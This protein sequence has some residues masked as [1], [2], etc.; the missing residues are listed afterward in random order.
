MNL[1]KI[2]SRFFRNKHVFVG[3]P[4]IIKNSNGDILLG[5]RDDNAPFYPSTWGLPGG[6]IEYGERIEDATKR[7]VE[8]E[9][10]I[11]IRIIRKSN[12]IYENFPNKKCRIHTIDI[13]YYAKIIKGFPKPKDE[14]SE[15]GWFSRSKIEKMILAYSH[16]EILRGEGLI[17]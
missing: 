12:N 10:G 1:I 4:V 16:K 15:V 6:M 2:A 3:V 5:K 17:K 9:M 14:T 11:K 7:E 13:P 8:E